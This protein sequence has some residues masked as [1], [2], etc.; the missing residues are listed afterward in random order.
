MIKTIK[1]MQPE[2]LKFHD[3]AEGMVTSEGVILSLDSETHEI[4]YPLGRAWVPLGAEVLI[5]A[6]VDDLILGAIREAMHQERRR[7]RASLGVDEP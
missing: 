7:P 6:R 4:E 2:P 3:L 5:L 1:Q